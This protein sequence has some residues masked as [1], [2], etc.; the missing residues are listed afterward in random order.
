AR[1]D[2]R[3][4]R[5]HPQVG[6]VGLDH[7]RIPR[8]SG[9]ALRLLIVG[10]GDVWVDVDAVAGQECASVLVGDGP[11]FVVA[12]FPTEP[13]DL[14]PRR[15]RIFQRSCDDGPGLGP[16]DVGQFGVASGFAVTPL[17]VAG[18]VGQGAYR[19]LG[20]GVGGHRPTQGL[21]TFTDQSQHFGYTLRSQV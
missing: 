19:V 14:L 10:G 2:E 12:A 9:R 20:R 17:G 4:T 11:F 18:G 7:H 6:V 16:V 8:F 13:G 15:C 1:A 5:T 21:A 3:S